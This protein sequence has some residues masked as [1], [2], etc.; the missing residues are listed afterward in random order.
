MWQGRLDDALQ[1]N[2]YLIEQLEAS[3]LGSESI[4]PT[5]GLDQYTRRL[6]QV[7]KVKQNDAN[8]YFD[9]LNF[10]MEMANWKWP[11]NHIDFETSM[12]ALPFYKD[13]T[14][15]SPIAF[16]WSHH[17]MHQNG[18]IEHF[19]QFINFEKGLFPNLEFIRTLKSSLSRNEGTIFRY[20]NHENT[21]LRS[22]YDQII[23]SEII[24]EDQ[25]KNE[26]LEFIDS[27]TRKKIDEKNYV[28]GT[29]NM[30]DL[31]EIVKSY[32]FSP[33]SQ[34]KI[35]LKFILPSIIHD[36]PFLRDKYGRKGIYGKSL[37]VTSLN[38]ED[39]Q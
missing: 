8:Y 38:F 22:I 31:Y 19:G 16:Q 32:Y 9:R 27:I 4:K 33:Y 30:V 7:E 25:E 29:R 13:K 24:V 6:L 28:C 34:G 14:P 1:Q 39:H 17:I 21:I 35:G 11:L 26:L 20:H 2:K 5:N 37:Q 23:S 12:V 18:K 36:V 10:E 15:Y 3:D